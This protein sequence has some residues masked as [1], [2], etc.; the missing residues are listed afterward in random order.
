M[1]APHVQ[2]QP[3]FRSS[4]WSNTSITVQQQQIAQASCTV[5]LSSS[6]K[7]TLG[8]P[9]SWQKSCLRREQQTGSS[10]ASSAWP[11]PSTSPPSAT[12]PGKFFILPCFC[13]INY[14]VT[15]AC[16]HDSR[17][18][19]TVAKPGHWFWFGL[20]TRPL[21]FKFLRPGYINKKLKNKKCVCMNKNNVNLLVYSLTPESGI[22]Y[23]F[24]FIF[25]LFV[26]LFY[27][28][29]KIKKYVHA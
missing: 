24:K 2:Q 25:F 19:A 4:R 18:H 12:S 7:A 15:V 11:S 5:L 27:L 9:L 23:R 14:P 8:N 28:A 20:V 13:Q 3:S 16:M 10:T 26:I 17:M 22:K 21:Y 6:M 29:R 1:R